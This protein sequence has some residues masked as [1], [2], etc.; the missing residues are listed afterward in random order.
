MM[1]LEVLHT[2]ILLALNNFYRMESELEKA[3]AMRKKILSA[4]SLL[5]IKNILSKRK[6]KDGSNSYQNTLDRVEEAEKEW[7][8]L[9]TKQPK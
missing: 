5:G 7:K 3:L 1:A 8:T 4:L 6:E 2:A 9:Q